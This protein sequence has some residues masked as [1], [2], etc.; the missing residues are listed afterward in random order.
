MSPE[1]R[2]AGKDTTDKLKGMREGKVEG[3]VKKKER[4]EG[5]ATKVAGF[6]S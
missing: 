5:R 6:A 4:Y 2:R 3:D 1:G